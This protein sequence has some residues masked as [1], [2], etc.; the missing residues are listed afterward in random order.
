MLRAAARVKAADLEQAL[1]MLPFHDALRLLGYLRDGLASGAEVCCLQCTAET[2]ICNALSLPGLAWLRHV[3][4][5]VCPHVVLAQAGCKF[6]K[7]SCNTLSSVS[8]A[9]LAC[10]P[11]CRLPQLCSCGV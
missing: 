2:F 5:G 6:S 3:L 4:P 8:A 7:A 11:G 1:L 10:L 9:S